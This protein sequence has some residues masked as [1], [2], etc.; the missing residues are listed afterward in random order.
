M[1]AAIICHF[2]TVE[3]MHKI[4]NALEILGAHT[5]KQIKIRNG[6]V[7]YAELLNFK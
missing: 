6:K 7:D 3:E 4:D 5:H 2:S 1:Y